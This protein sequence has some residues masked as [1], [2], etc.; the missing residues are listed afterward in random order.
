MIKLRYNPVAIS[1][2]EEIKEYISEDN[3][4]AAV[5]IVKELIDKT[6]SL[7][8]FPNM[9]LSLGRKIGLETKYKYLICN[10]YIIF[11][12]FEENTISIMRIIHGKRD[13]LRLLDL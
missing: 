5:K 1:D 6:E 9:G 12:I 7:I 10:Q 11:Y 8:D 4:T 3:E 13:Y 2:L